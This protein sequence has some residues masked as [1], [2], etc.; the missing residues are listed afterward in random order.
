MPKVKND[1]YTVGAGDNTLHITFPLTTKSGS[2]YGVFKCYVTCRRWVSENNR[3]GRL[4][5]TTGV[6]LPREFWDTN[7]NEIKPSCPNREQIRASL[8]AI[9]EQIRK[10]YIASEAYSCRNNGV[11]TILGIDEVKDVIDGKAYQRNQGP[12][13]LFTR[14]HNE[15]TPSEFGGLVGEF[16]RRYTSR[17]GRKL[18]EMTSNYKNFQTLCHNLEKFLSK[19]YPLGFSIDRIQ[20]ELTEFSKKWFRF[21]TQNIEEA[22]STISGLTKRLRQVLL[23]AIDENYI[24][25]ISL[26]CLR[27]SHTVNPM[28]ALSEQVLSK[29]YRHV[30]SEKQTRLEKARDLFVVLCLT[31]LRYSDLK[32]LNNAIK[33]GEA[34]LHVPTSKNGSSVV[35]PLFPA[36][37]EILKKYPNGLPIISNQNLNSYIKEVFIVVGLT[38]NVVVKQQRGNNKTEVSRQR[39][40]DVVTAHTGRRTFVS[41]CRTRGILDQIIMMVTGHSNLAQLNTYTSI[42][43]SEVLYAF[44][45]ERDTTNN[46]VEPMFS[47]SKNWIIEAQNH[48]SSDIPDLN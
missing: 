8:A 31:A 1:R 41:I 12:L 30:F 46:F 9:V 22:S 24:P 39:L 14:N 25:H 35:I 23:W 21:L 37:I 17:D 34:S 29:L 4:R 45:H 11:R 10:A 28:I 48:V 40:C 38:D 44:G 36:T 7:K 16:M 42:P 26:K 15:N 5:H 6:K 32:K 47:L 20:L 43:D 3:E 19:Y 18:I 27:F 2:Q 13:A 33:V